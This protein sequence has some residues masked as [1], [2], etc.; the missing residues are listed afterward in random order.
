MPQVPRTWT[1]ERNA[2]LRADS[3]SIFVPTSEL[4][5]ARVGDR[6]VVS[7][8]GHGDEQTGTVVDIIRDGQVPSL[9]LTLDPP[10]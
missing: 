2:P 7:G 1:I 3:E 10:R 4:P 8:S 5:R 9:R 6:V